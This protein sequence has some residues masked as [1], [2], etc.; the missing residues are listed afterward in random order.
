[1]RRAGA[2]DD[3]V[4]L[5][6]GY[7]HRQ[8]DDYAN[9]RRE[10][11]EMRA[12]VRRLSG[13][14]RAHVS[15]Y[16]ASLPKPAAALPH[17][18]DLYLARCAQCHGDRGQG[19]GP[20]NPPIAGLSPAYIEAQLLA[21]RTGKRRGDAMGEMIAVSRA[22][23]PDQIRALAGLA[24]APALPASPRPPPGRRR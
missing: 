16:Y 5:N 2:R 3:W 15:A 4:G 20:A 12:V 9:G 23:T 8:L 10:H 13:E 1:M 21:W 22:L 17:V 11:K 24:A 7:L 19:R 18:S 6:A 14:D